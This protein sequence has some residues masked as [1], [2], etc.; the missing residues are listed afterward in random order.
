MLVEPMQTPL[1]LCLPD[2]KLPCY[3]SNSSSSRQ[4]RLHQ[5][6]VAAVAQLQQG[7]SS[8]RNAVG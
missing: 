8:M 2:C 4:L 6:A 5:A 3:H 7:Q 1:V